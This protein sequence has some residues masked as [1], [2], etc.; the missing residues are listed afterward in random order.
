MVTE[1]RQEDY[2]QLAVRFVKLSDKKN[3]LLGSGTLMVYEN[4]Q[5]AFVLTAA[6]VVYGLEMDQMQLTLRLKDGQDCELTV[7]RIIICPEYTHDD[8]GDNT[9]FDAAILLVKW[10]EW[11]AGLPFLKLEDPDEGKDQILW[12]YPGGEEKEGLDGRSPLT[13]KIANSSPVWWTKLNYHFESAVPQ[14]SRKAYMGGFSGGGMYQIRDYGFTYSGAIS[15][16]SGDDTAG[17]EAKVTR[18]SLFRKMMEEEGLL[19]EPVVDLHDYM[20]N[21]V[22]KI[23]DSNKNSRNYFENAMDELLESG[24]TP[25]SFLNEGKDKFATLPCLYDKR[26][27]CHVYWEGQM[28]CAVACCDLLGESPENLNQMQVTLEDGSQVNIEVLCTEEKVETC[29]HYMLKQGYFSD[30]GNIKNESILLWANNKMPIYGQM[31]KR[32]A[33]ANIMDDIISTNRILGS[34][35]RR[36]LKTDGSFHIVKGKID[37]FHVGVLGIGKIVNDVIAD[38]EGD[39]DEMKELLGKVWR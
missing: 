19:L 16:G 20:E 10:E 27:R 24:V 25:D 13:G 36:S 23:E 34:E 39:P 30:K 12:G 37:N 38:A 29:M 21:N 35:L 17:G 31:K 4:E 18:A 32:T 3:L 5:A 26:E 11:M 1:I 28:T 22:R 7:E 9:A 6:H 33:I 14:R 2:S 15:G 8:R